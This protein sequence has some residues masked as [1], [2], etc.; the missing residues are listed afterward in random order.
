MC[1]VPNANSDIGQETIEAPGL[2]NLGKW[3]LDHSGS[4]AHW[5]GEIYQGKKLRELVR[6]QPQESIGV[7]W[8]RHAFRG[9]IAHNGR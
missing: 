5:L 4:P 7:V 3:M 2:P 1:P 6:H 9:Y 8:F